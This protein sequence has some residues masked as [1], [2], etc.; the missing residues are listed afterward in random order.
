VVTVGS[1]SGLWRSWRLERDDV[2]RCSS[3]TRPIGGKDNPLPTG[4]SKQ[5]R[6]L[7]TT[8]K[9]DEESGLDPS[10][11]FSGESPGSDRTDRAKGSISPT[12][13]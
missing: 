6:G 11:G 3:K 9:S 13:P 7:T 8:G 2:V 12:R 5:R 10:I 1:G 4:N